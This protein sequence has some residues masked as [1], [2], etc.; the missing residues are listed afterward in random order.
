M[1]FDYPV[2][3]A[4]QCETW[5][6]GQ[7]AQHVLECEA[8]FGV[9]ASFLHEPEQTVKLSD[10]WTFQHKG[11]DMRRTAVFLLATTILFAGTAEART[12]DLVLDRQ[13][14]EVEPGRKDM[15]ITVNGGITA[16]V[17]RFTDGETATIRVTNHL[18]ETTSIHWHGLL[19]PGSKD[20]AP[21]FNGFAGIKPGETYTYTFNLR[22][23]GT[24]WYHAHSATQEQEG[25]YGAFIIDPKAGSDIAV[26]ADRDEVVLLSEHTRTAPERILR[27]LKGDSGYYNFSKRTTPELFRDVAKFGLKK[28]L[29]DRAAWNKMRMDPTDIAD[30][31]NYTLLVNGQPS[32]RKPYFAFAPGEKV[33]LRIINGSAM[34]FM[35][36]SIP[37]LAMTVVAA[38]GRAVEP[39]TVD[40]FRIGVAETYD[41]IVEPKAG[42]AYPLWVETLDR[43][44]SVLAAI[45]PR[46]GMAV[47]GPA[48][49]PRQVL[50]MSEM[51]SMGTSMG[52][53]AK[54]M[55]GMNSSGGS[56]PGMD[57]SDGKSMTMAGM[58]H[59][60]R[61]MPG[62]DMSGKAVGSAKSSAGSKAGSSHSTSGAMAGMDM[63]D[64]KS[65]A[66]A[67]MD[68]SGGSMQGMDMS[69]TAP[70]SSDHATMPGMAGAT[71]M[72]SNTPTR[73]GSAVQ[74]TSSGKKETPFPRVDYGMGSDTTAGMDG[75]AMT[76]GGM[77]GMTGNSQAMAGMDMGS[78]KMAMPMQHTGMAGGSGSMAGMDMSGGG[79]SM[80]GMAGMSMTSLADEGDTD[81][82][83][84]VFGWATGAPYG[85]RVLSVKDLRALT[86]QRDTRAP[87]RTIVIKVSGNMERYI[88]TLNGAKF[89][90][91]PPLKVA[92]G[93]RVRITF[94]N[95][96]MM[97]HPMHLHGM[98]F[99]VENGQ[100]AD[101]LP[102]KNVVTIAPGKTQS[103]LLTAD[104]AGE[105]P[106]HCHLLYHMESGMMQKLIV[107]SVSQPNG[108][109]APA[110]QSM[111]G[112]DH[113][114]GTN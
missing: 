79:G 28:T 32:S 61:S 106:L 113:G 76:D 40:E 45:A 43:R 70:A 58:D 3:F 34:S 20:G 73:S 104:E 39:V 93:E 80:A 49:R 90:E 87:T 54:P 92:F 17:L 55:A 62:M 103:I 97:A 74:A 14:V 64:G 59:S 16:P 30:V 101:R 91:A 63:G 6:R 4:H 60:S 105:W 22:Q 50:L 29:A 77:P 68:H 100:S 47:T 82:S 23:T 67:G 83:G 69:G 42:R 41:V 71:M 8:P 24:Y 18:K 35:D 110:M 94:V 44:A 95:E 88:W 11:I 12:Y 10:G 48:P 85:A 31:G 25:Q 86:P 19:V 96:T 7:A 1:E 99:Q 65:M 75:M 57:M 51:G 81:G 53:D 15:A 46:E 78:G 37:G 84:R 26:N 56:M 112:M 107:A 72:A 38:D 27:N 13:K 109:P 52:G 108:M 21:G 2:T 114:T 111:P 66:M 33:R 36:V 5:M 9:L 98:F 89:G 102:D